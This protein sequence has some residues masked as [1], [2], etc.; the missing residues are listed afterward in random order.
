MY[1]IG[2]LFRALVCVCVKRAFIIFYVHLAPQQIF[3]PFIDV[4]HLCFYQTTKSI[5]YCYPL[6]HKYL[7]YEFNFLLNKF[8][9]I[10]RNTDL[11][12]YLQ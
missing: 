7:K 10:Y 1:S 4:F 9:I 6:G 12:I 8:N 2:S 5:L 3:D 11:N